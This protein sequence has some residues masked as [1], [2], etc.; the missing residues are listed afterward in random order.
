MPSFSK[1]EPYPKGT[2]D[3]LNELGPDRFSE[4]LKAER[5][6]HFT[7]TTMRD[8][9][10]SLLATR[11]R[12]LDM[13]KVAEGYAKNHPE[14]FSMEVWGG[15]TFDVCLRFLYEN[16]WERLIKLRKAMPN[17]LLQ[18]LIRGSNGVGYTAYPDNLIEKFVI[19]SYESG[20]DIFR[21]FDSLNWMKSIA[22]CIEFVRK[23]TKG[24][25]EGAICYTGD[26][27]DPKK[28]KYNLS[29]YLK[30]AKEIENA[31]AHILAI[32]DMAGLLKPYAATELITALKSEV[33]I[34]IHLHTHDTSSVQAA[35]YLKAIEAGVDVVDVA[36]GGMSG[37]TSQPNF[38]SLLEVLRFTEREHEMDREKLA[39]YSNYWE[40]VRKYYY[41]YESGLKSGA[42]EV[43]QH[44][45]PGGQ[46]SNLKG[47]A[48]AL[49]LE[50]K[51]PEVTKMYAEVNALFGDIIKVTP[52]SKVVGD[53]S[54][55]LISNHLTVQDVLDKGDSLSFPESVKSFFRGDLG[56]P[57]GGFSQKLQKIILKDEKPYLNRPNA[58]LAPIDFVAEFDAFKQKFSNGMGRV[59]EFTDFLSFKLYPKVFADAY[60]HHLKY[61]NVMN[62]PT[63]NFLYGME[64]GEEIMIELDKGKNVL[65]SLMHK[66]EAD[67]QGMVSLYFKIN[68]Q[69]RNI[70]VQ[71][72][73]I[74]TTKIENLKA[75]PQKEKEIGSPLQGMLSN[76]LV[77]KGEVVEKDQAL[78]TIEAMKMETTITS[79]VAGIVEKIQ[80]NKGALVNSEDLILVIQ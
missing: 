4:W 74:Q 20:I 1:Y 58:H 57:V 55:Y 34:P 75:D 15:A 17:V 51:F 37:L 46:Y 78:F 7:D 70:Q 8:A 48:A 33:K 28:T 2:K 43:Y 14:I 10:Q 31:G 61:G 49:G 32:K 22:P 38:N 27:L 16:P 36:L 77:E 18:M 63:K 3:L 53:M 21:I 12:T 35:T 67:A 41:T 73:S 19:K 39:E 72:R 69:F 79:A 60:E 50:E 26:I 13:L 40:T 45:I 30:L 44:E 66:G 68:G 52:S 25:A 56:Q 47:Q 76:V 59:L 65:I 23:N 80:L 62:I 64:V 24:L 42:G 29:Y 11:M 54:Q 5:K 9:H 71:D 6:I